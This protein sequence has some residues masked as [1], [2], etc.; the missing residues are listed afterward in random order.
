MIINN[1]RA[2][3]VKWLSSLWTSIAFHFLNM[4][5]SHFRHFRQWLLSTETTMPKL[6]LVKTL[7]KNPNKYMCILNKYIITDLPTTVSCFWMTLKR[8]KVILHNYS[9]L[10]NR[11]IYDVARLYRPLPNKKHFYSLNC[12][13]LLIKRNKW[14]AYSFYIWQQCIF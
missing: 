11:N 3:L 7:L 4:A 10:Q 1:N 13:F 9:P 12:A 5:V 6:C 2:V 14:S 8:N